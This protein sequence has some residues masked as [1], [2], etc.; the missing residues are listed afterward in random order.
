VSTPAAARNSR[1]MA[2]QLGWVYGSKI[3]GLHVV[4]DGN[5]SEDDAQRAHDFCDS[6]P[7]WLPTQPS[8]AVYH[9]VRGSTW[10]AG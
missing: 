2:T 6:V 8:T 9:D 1:N 5:A 4:V 10:A 7:L 3:V